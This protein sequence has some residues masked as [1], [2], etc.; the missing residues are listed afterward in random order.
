MSFSK[1]Y[2]AEIILSYSEPIKYALNIETKFWKDLFG[3]TLNKEYCK[4]M[5][6]ITNFISDYSKRLSRPIKDLDDVRNAME[7]LDHIRQNEIRIDMTLGPIEV[8]QY[9]FFLYDMI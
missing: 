6:D 8:T 3:K 9:P 1:A 7:A 5:D 2:L 4:K